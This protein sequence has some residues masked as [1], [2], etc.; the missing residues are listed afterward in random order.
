M[1]RHERDR[2]RSDELRGDREVAFVLAV[3]VVDTT[4][5]LPERMSSIASSMVANG[6]A[7][8]GAVRSVA[9]TDRSLSA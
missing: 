6:D 2:L 7:V 3:G 5:N 8:S 1:G 4:T 9:T